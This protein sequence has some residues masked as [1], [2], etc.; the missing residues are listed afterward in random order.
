MASI[1][2]DNWRN[3]L[4]LPLII[5]GTVLY[6][7]LLKNWL[8]LGV[9][10]YYLLQISY[11]KKFDLLLISLGMTFL[12]FIRVPFSQYE[13][14]PTQTSLNLQITIY[15]D[16]I[17]TNGT[18]VTAEG[19]T[20]FGQLTFQY[21]TKNQAELA[22]WQK[23]GTRNQVIQVIGSFKEREGAR[24]LHGFNRMDYEFSRNQLGTFVIEK[25]EGETPLSHLSKGRKIRAQA[26]DWVEEKFPPDLARYMK[27]LLLGYRDQ[28]F[29]AI[30]EAYSSSGILHLFSISGMH[31]AIFLSWF[32]YA[33]R[34]S[35]LVMEEFIWPFLAIMVF[36]LILFGQGISI[37]RATI[38]YLVNFLFKSKQIYLSAYDR[39]AICLFFLLLIEP[40]TFLQTSGILSILLSF[41]LL[42][43]ANIEKNPWRL[44]MDIGLLASPILM[45]L[46]Y[47]VSLVD[48]ILTALVAP[49]F[50]FFLLPGFV[51]LAC[52]TFLKL[53]IT[54]LIAFFHTFIALL[55][56]SLQFSRHFVFI[57]GKPS[58]FFVF[59]LLVFSL[60]CYPNKK[61]RKWAFIFLLFVTFIPKWSIKTA[62]SFVDVGQ[63]DS[64]VFQS[65]GN[66]EVYIIDTGGKINFN[67]ESQI[68]LKNAEYTLVPFLKGEGI[69]TID[70]LFLT[71]GDIDHVGDLSALIQN[72][73][74]KTIY[75][76]QGSLQHP[77][78]VNLKEQVE[79]STKI[80][81][82][83]AG[84]QVGQKIQFRVLSP[85]K[86]GK[87]ANNDSL[88]LTNRIKG[89]QFLLMGDLEEEGEAQLLKNEPDLKADI[90]KLGHHG[91]KTSSTAPFI[92]QVQPQHGII[93][94]GVKNQFKHPNPEVLETLE[95]YQVK[96]YR[97]DQQGMIRYEWRFFSHYPKVVTLKEG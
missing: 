44:S 91:S 81:E 71:H 80:I 85:N 64:I 92:K 73:S 10:A 32:F 28:S 26:I 45:Y 19:K 6:A 17:K 47:E 67:K 83:K 46:F 34:R 42:T 68:S 78:M 56:R 84:D 97:T 5:S 4:L 21:Q 27:A 2:G 52:L 69:R 43:C 18:F 1:Q 94:C 39:L 15:P 88:V 24:N 40:K 54:W 7:L 59:F 50:S 76:S 31:L 9:A 66:K 96:I 79:A 61:W 90:L 72:F 33:F 60:Y 89:L 25:I 74:I 75:I 63:G 14:P 8:L 62:V 65:F 20:V 38:M 48:G 51:M 93:S 23:R 22:R 37:W 87:G 3:Y 58:L 41:I 86:L 16:T 77:N 35:Q 30:R 57:T 95:R 36:L 11:Y 29:Q 53:P 49:I 55:E 70:G 13:L 82:L 12:F